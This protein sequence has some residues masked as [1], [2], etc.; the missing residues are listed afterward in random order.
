[1][2]KILLSLA[3][4]VAATAALRA[5]VRLPAV[6]SKHMVLQRD[7]VV[8]LWGWAE[9]GEK[10]TVA[11]AGQTR[12]ATA[13][14]DGAWRVALDPL[15]A[16][17]EPATMTITGKNKITIEDVLVGEVW[18]GSGQSN[19]AWTVARSLNPEAEAMAAN[20]PRIRFFK[21]TSASANR[22]DLVG[23]PLFFRPRAAPETRRA[24]RPDQLVG[25]RHADR[26][27]D[28]AGGAAGSEGAGAVF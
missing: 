1:M 14:A 27:L 21:E 6:I 15:R 23:D 19:M 24:C 16:S 18:L 13:A 5:D 11:F 4:A 20:F 28:R 8:P 22:G 17:T 26:G 25:R 9:P 3:L 12:T 7:A 10:V 2:K